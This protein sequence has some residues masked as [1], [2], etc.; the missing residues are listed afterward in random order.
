MP[1]QAQP[2]E[3]GLGQP[4]KLCSWGSCWAHTF[5]PLHLELQGPPIQHVR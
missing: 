3:E 1:E 2:P 4:E 5:S